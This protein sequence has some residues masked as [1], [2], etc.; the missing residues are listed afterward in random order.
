MSLS[1]WCHRQQGQRRQHQAAP[2]Q[3]REQPPLSIND[4]RA[5]LRVYTPTQQKAESFQ[6]PSVDPLAAMASMWAN[7]SSNDLANGQGPSN[8]NH[9]D[10]SESNHANHDGD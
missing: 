4:F 7:L 1:G 9:G 3:A 8:G 10:N 6:R 2:V 5:A